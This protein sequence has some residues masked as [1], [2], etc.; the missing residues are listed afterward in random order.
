MKMSQL[1]GRIPTELQIASFIVTKGVV[2]LAENVMQEL[3]TAWIVHSNCTAADSGPTP[4][5]SGVPAWRQSN[6]T[7]LSD[8]RE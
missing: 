8:E 3:T 6:N 5:F 7:S 4:A 1:S 2:V